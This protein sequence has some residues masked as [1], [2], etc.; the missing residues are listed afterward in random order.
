MKREEDSL[1]V[2]P[3]DALQRAIPQKYELVLTATR[4]AKQLLRQQQM[5]GA[6]A[7]DSARSYK[8]LSVALQEIADGRIG[9][10][11]LT[12]PDILAEDFEEEQQ[13]Y[14]PEIDRFHRE[15]DEELDAADDED[16]DD[17]MEEDFEDEADEEEEADVEEP[18]ES[19]GSDE[20]VI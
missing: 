16:E 6:M 5:A 20:P 19:E 11:Q 15:P 14:F 17:E 8:P 18:A 10:E 3:L 4:R 13:D 1:M 9:V 12:Q 2:P 7:D